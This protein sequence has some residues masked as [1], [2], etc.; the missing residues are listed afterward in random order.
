MSRQSRSSGS[1]S[2]QASTGARQSLGEQLR[3]VG[4]KLS[5]Q[6]LDRIK[7]GSDLSG[8]IKAR[9]TKLGISLPGSGPRER[10]EVP[11]YGSSEAEGMFPA[12]FDYQSALNLVN[13]QGNIDTQ[14]ANLNSDASKYI[15]QLQ[16]GGAKDVA[17]IQG[18]TAKYVADRELEGNLG[19]ENI[20]TRGAIDLQGIVNAGMANVENIRGEYGVKG[21]K[22]DR[23]TAIL[24][25][26]VSAFN[27]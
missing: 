19:V 5:S 9:A 6:E 23:S 15:T 1:N 24:G 22:V 12:E 10:A 27:F 7:E 25:G 26:L 4:G 8:G 13:A 11:G 21:K 2:G 3:N 17:N 14:I 16:V 20:R 18:G